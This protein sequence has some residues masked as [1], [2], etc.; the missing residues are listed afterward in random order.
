V[1]PKLK[2]SDSS[3]ARFGLLTWLMTR[4]VPVSSGS[5]GSRVWPTFA[6]IDV[7]ADCCNEGA[8]KALL[9]EARSVSQSVARQLRPSFGSVVV[10][11]P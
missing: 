11:S 5:S 2:F 9:P 8:L 7:L 6:V 3:G 1:T 10:N 4:N